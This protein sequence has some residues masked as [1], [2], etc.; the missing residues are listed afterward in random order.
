MV[1]EMRYW[2]FVHPRRGQSATPTSTPGRMVLG[3]SVSSSPPRCS[4]QPAGTEDHFHQSSTRHETE[5]RLNTRA[6]PDVPL[7]RPVV[8]GVSE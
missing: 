3:V 2:L 8:P 1:M 5:G 7:A 4:V 6:D